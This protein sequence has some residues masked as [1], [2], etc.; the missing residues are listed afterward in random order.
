L[1]HEGI[2][3]GFV[4]EVCILDLYG[5]AGW[6]GIGDRGIGRHGSTEDADCC[7]VDQAGL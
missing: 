2:D 5:W 4:L 3:V 1:T 7:L 6:L